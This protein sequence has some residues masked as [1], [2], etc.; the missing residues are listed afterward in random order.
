MGLAVAIYAATVYMLHFT[1]VMMGTVFLSHVVGGKL[2]L[3]PVLRRLAFILRSGLLVV[4]VALGLSAVRVLPISEYTP[5][6]NRGAISLEQIEKA[7]EVPSL[8]FVIDRIFDQIGSPILA[9]RGIPIALLVIAGLV[10]APRR[11]SFFLGLSGLIGVWAS[12]GNQAPIDL[13]ALF[14]YLIPNFRFNTTLLRTLELTYLAIPLLT[15]FGLHGTVKWSQ[16]RHGSLVKPVNWCC[17]SHGRHRRCSSGARYS[18][19][20]TRFHRSTFSISQGWASTCVTGTTC[21]CKE[22]RQNS[23]HHTGHYLLGRWRQA[24]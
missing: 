21:V 5:I 19:R 11:V 16:T 22:R 2:S 20:S 24:C 12:L 8:Q 1:L 23:D 13:Y 14:Y 15:A 4:V 10:F 9:I 7:S 6:S 3:R 17:V 18:P